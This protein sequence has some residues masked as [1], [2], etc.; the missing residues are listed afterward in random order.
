VRVWSRL[1]FTPVAW[2]DAAESVC[3]LL[4]ALC[5]TVL[6]CASTT[7]PRIMLKGCHVFVVACSS[8]PSLKLYAK[9]NFALALD[10]SRTPQH[11]ATH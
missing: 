2:P 7:H 10:S 9:L 11:T 5:N 1:V 6:H 8:P 3:P 4:G